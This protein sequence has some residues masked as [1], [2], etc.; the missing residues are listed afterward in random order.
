MRR[1][2]TTL[3]AAALAFTLALP[4]QAE[5]MDLDSV[6]AT[7]NGQ[8]ITLGHMLVIRAQLPE[9]YQQLGDEVLWDGILDQ[10]VQQTVLAQDDRAEETKRVTLSLDNERR[11]LMAAEVVQAI[12]NDAVSDDAVQAAYDA[13]YATAELGKEFNAS[14]ILVETEEEAQA[15]IEELNGGADF[16]E[17]AK[18]KSTGPSG[19]NGGELGWFGPGMM[20]EPFQAAVEQMSVGEISAPVQTQF[21]WHVIKLNEERNKEAPQLEEVRAD[22]E[23]KLQQEAVQNYI[24]EKLGAAEVTRTDKADID[25]SVLSNMQL[26]EE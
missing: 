19:P 1:T 22:I 7:V 20:V 10:I 24:D 5:E 16:A 4:A 17:L 12:A 3:T 8:D 13:E 9:Q 2:L 6:V 21:G 23:L 26:L 11:S 14:H 18:T 15:L 25:T